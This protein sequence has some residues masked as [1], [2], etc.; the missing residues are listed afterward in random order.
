MLVITEISE[1]SLGTKIFSYLMVLIF[2]LTKNKG[3][4]YLHGYIKNVLIL[5]F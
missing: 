2:N 4:H 1:K 5:T 3:K